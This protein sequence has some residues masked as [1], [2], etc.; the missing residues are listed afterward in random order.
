MLF[1]RERRG[2]VRLFVAAL[3]A[4]HRQNALELTIR[5]ANPS[6]AQVYTVIYYTNTGT[7]TPFNSPSEF[8]D[9]IASFLQS[10]A[11]TSP[12]CLEV[13]AKDPCHNKAERTRSDLGTPSQILPYD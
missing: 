6:V 1:T 10:K 2:C 9:T 5:N 3:S 13:R 11:L 12:A 8:V 4:K 7:Q